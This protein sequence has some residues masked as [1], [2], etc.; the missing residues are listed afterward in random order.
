MLIHT[1]LSR[2]Q[3]AREGIPTLKNVFVIS[4]KVKSNHTKSIKNHQNQANAN[5]INR[6]QANSNKINQSQTKSIKIEQTQTKSIK[7][8]QN[9][10]TSNKIKQTQTKSIKIKQHHQ[11]QSNNHAQKNIFRCSY[12]PGRHLL[13][14]TSSYYVNTI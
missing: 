9:Q 2:T 6:N 13:F 7:I 11:N 4:T 3:A 1:L 10:P 5:K 8:K 12:P 14:Q